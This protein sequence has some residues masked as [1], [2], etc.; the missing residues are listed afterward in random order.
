MGFMLPGPGQLVDVV[1]VTG[2]VLVMVARGLLAALSF[3]LHRPPGD[4]SA[5]ASDMDELGGL[6]RP[7]ALHRRGAGGRAHGGLRPARFRRISP[8]R[9]RDVRRVEIAARRSW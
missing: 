6:L 9:S 3:G 4:K 1:G 8:V 7:A 2:A 5:G